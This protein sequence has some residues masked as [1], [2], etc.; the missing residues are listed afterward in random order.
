V[1][2]DEPVVER[3][4]RQADGTWLLTTFS[5]RD[6]KLALATVPIRVKLAEIYAGLTFPVSPAPPTRP[7]RKRRSCRPLIAFNGRL[8]LRLPVSIWE[9]EIDA[10]VGVAGHFAQRCQLL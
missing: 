9:V 8:F 4:H 6:A 7:V 2:P 5:G 3:P 10:G 1:S